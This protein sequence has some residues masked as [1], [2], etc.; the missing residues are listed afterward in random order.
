MA[1]LIV[2]RALACWFLLRR[3]YSNQLRIAAFVWAG[4]S[5]ALATARVLLQQGFG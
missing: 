3:G 4:F 1:A 5:L 2:A